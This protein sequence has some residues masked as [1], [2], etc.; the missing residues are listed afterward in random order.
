M[1]ELEYVC[2]ALFFFFF[3]KGGRGRNINLLFHSFTHSLADSCLCPDQGLNLQPRHIRAM[4]KPTELPDQSCSTLIKNLQN[5][6]EQCT[7]SR[8]AQLVNQNLNL[9]TFILRSLILNQG[10]L[11]SDLDLPFGGPGMGFR[12]AGIW[13]LSVLEGTFTPVCHTDIFVCVCEHET[14]GKERGWP[15]ENAGD[16]KKKTNSV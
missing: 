8:L 15:S 12:C 3:K 6:G 1:F 13:L 14:A 16:S 7:V 10:M 4:L 5:T 9:E 2:S 11:F